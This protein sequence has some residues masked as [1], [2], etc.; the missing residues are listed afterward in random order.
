MKKILFIAL[1]GLMLTGC[2]SK[3]GAFIESIETK[4]SMPTAIKQL[5]EALEGKGLT[6]ID[7]IDHAK[8]AKKLGLRLNPQR[9]VTFGN[10]LIGAKLIECNPS[11]GL[12]LPLRMLFSSDYEGRITVIY[13]NPEYWSL[14]HN[15]KDKTCLNIVRQASAA[16][17]ALA[18]AAAAKR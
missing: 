16:M 11:I 14:K 9:V 10:P 4:N 1:L 12:D 3:K 17:Q 15:M 5:K 8:R 2:D 18:K 13:T 6:Y 7:T